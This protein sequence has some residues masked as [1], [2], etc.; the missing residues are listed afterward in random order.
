VLISGGHWFKNDNPSLRYAAG[1]LSILLCVA[2]TDVLADVTEWP[3]RGQLTRQRALRTQDWKMTKQIA[4]LEKYKDRVA[5]GRRSGARKQET[6]CRR[7]LSFLQPR[8]PV[9]HLPVLRFQSS[10]SP[11]R[12]RGLPASL[13]AN[14]LPGR[15][16]YRSR[17]SRGTS[18]RSAVAWRYGNRLRYP[19]NN[20]TASDEK[21]PIAVIIYYAALLPRRGPHIASHSVC[22]SVRPSRYGCR[23][24]RRAT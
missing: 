14:Q 12:A 22:P 10:H 3:R 18:P 21:I 16:C 13:N 11:A 7:V 6:A 24:S 2:M 19:Q 5:K 20:A 9:R 4:A 15:S 17:Q 23:A 1:L 8:C